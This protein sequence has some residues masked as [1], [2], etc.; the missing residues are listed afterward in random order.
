MLDCGMK[1]YRFAILGTG[2]IAR[3]HARAV[4][5]VEGAQLCAVCSRSAQRAAEFAAE[6]DCRACTD[7]EV[8][9][10][11]EAIDVLLIA[12]PSGAHLEPALTAAC[13]GVHALVEKPLEISIERA[14]RMTAAHEAAGTTLGCIFQM[15]RM[16]VLQPIR[17]AITA[18]RFGTV[19][20]AA[21]FV[22]W[23]RDAE[24]YTQS[25]WHGTRN[26]DGG[27]ALMNQ[28]IHMID[29]LCDLMPPVRSVAAAV[30]S[31]GHTGIEVEDTSSAS[32]VF[33]GGALG[34]VIGT[35]ASWP[36][37]PK[38]LE[39]TGTAGTAII[40]DEHLL[41]YQFRDEQPDDE[42]IRTRF[43]AVATR[44]GVAD[45]GAMS[46]AGHTACIRSFIAALNE[47]CPYEVDGQA[48]C[49]SIALIEAIYR[50]AREKRIIE[51]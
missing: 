19:T 7:L 12:T 13:G 21:A 25:E 41:C 44:A 17:E 10:S 31:I 16:P 39:I 2:L 29:L 36:G 6:Y 1:H 15:R 47:G 28:S 24:Y 43:S 23:W 46:H 20:H 4:Q 14:Q 48:A 45:P 26:L 50:S 22:P 34:T 40:E 51:C 8:M 33:E 27:G 11:S 5:D 38:R 9:L 49:R 32:L 42:Q 3:F 37:R 18:G 30:S 35:T